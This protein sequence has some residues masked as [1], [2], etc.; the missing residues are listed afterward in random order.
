MLLFS[1]N[2]ESS[3]VFYPV[4]RFPVLVC[5]YFL[6]FPV[7]CVEAKSRMLGATVASLY[8]LFL[9]NLTTRCALFTLFPHAR[10]A[11]VRMQLLVRLA[12]C[13]SCL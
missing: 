2:R 8:C 1:Q 4:P 6:M 12:W 13:L 9:L 11:Q 10:V 3:A 7:T 5:C